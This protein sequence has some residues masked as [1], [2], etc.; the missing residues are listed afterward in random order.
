MDEQTLRIAPC[1][2]KGEIAI[3]TSKSHS[4]RALLFAMM[5]RGKSRIK[6]LLDST[7]TSAMCQAIQL[8][9]AKVERS[10]AHIEVIGGFGPV[11]EV[12]DAGRS[13]LVLRLIG[14]LAGLL[15][16]PTRLK[17]DER[18]PITPLL[19]GLEQLG[20]TIREGPTIQGPIRP[21]IARISGIDSQP[22]SGLLIAT[23]FLN[24]PSE[25][26]VSDPH[27]EPWIEMTLKWLN[28]LGCP[29][30]HKDYCHYL[31]PGS[32]S[33]KGFDYTVPGDF[34]SAAFSL[35]AALITGCSLTL[36][37]LDFDDVQGDKIFIDWLIQMGAKIE[38]DRAKKS[39]TID[40]S[41]PLKG[42]DL[43]LN[44]CI[45]ALP[46]LAVLGCFA[47][48]K[49]RLR[50]AA[51]ARLK[52]SD[53]IRAICSELKKMGAAIEEHPDGLSLTQSTLK[54]ASLLSHDDHRIAMSLAV[55]ALGA[56]GQT[57]IKGSACI[58]KTYP[59]FIPD[60]QKI[61]ASY[62]LVWV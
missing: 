42:A 19:L 44:L 38:I 41:H 35:A 1:S 47:S 32:L 9:G 5:G 43:D 22:V 51:G 4:L 46:I 34:S 14:A 12:I 2:L 52:E 57:Q 10:D 6:G 53:R 55:A 48:G 59:T 62:D 60:F 25:I 28:S 39:L 8:F 24:G 49:T 3:P 31:V 17:G 37:Q 40:G 54:G 58:A 36:T 26:I 20:A 18:R 21:G 23:S 50:G 11:T 13:G 29:I 61:G 56:Q 30:E 45:D 7:D 16:T 33:Y 15:P 27:E